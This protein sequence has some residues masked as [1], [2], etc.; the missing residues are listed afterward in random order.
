LAMS[1]TDSEGQF[2]LSRLLP[3]GESYSLIIIAKGYLPLSTDTLEVNINT[4]SP[5]ILRMELNSD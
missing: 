2:T 3:R 5:I 4:D 1:L